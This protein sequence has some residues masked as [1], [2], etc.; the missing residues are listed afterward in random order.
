MLSTV[1]RS[2]DRIPACTGCVTLGKSPTLAELPFRHLFNRDADSS[3]LPGY[4]DIIW[5]KA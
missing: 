5:D 1:V 4:V 2:T 3:C